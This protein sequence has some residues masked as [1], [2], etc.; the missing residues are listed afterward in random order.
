M[1]N[2]YIVEKKSYSEQGETYEIKYLDK[3]KI[4]SAIEEASTVDELI[5]LLEALEGEDTESEHIVADNIIIKALRLL[6]Q[7]K[8]AEEYDAIPKW[9]S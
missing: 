7:Y 9:Y 8:L 4:Y 3:Y 1:N 5:P 2:Y 6:G